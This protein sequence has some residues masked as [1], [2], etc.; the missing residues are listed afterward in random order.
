MKRYARIT[1]ENAAV[2]VARNKGDSPR[3]T[4][5]LALLE[6]ESAIRV[7]ERNGHVVERY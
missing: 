1:V 2:A 5:L 6:V 3:V 4:S 7:I